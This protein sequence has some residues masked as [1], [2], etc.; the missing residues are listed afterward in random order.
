MTFEKITLSRLESFLFKAADILRGKMGTSEFK[1]E[2]REL[3][4][5]VDVQLADLGP[6]KKTDKRKRRKGNGQ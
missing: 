1:A 4:R 5:Q 6:G 3:I 2:N